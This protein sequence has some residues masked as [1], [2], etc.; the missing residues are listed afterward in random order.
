M[1][2][3]N[4]QKIGALGELDAER[5]FLSWGWNVG[6]DRIDQGYDLFVA[7]TLKKFNGAR[8][9][10]QVKGTANRKKNWVVAQIEKSRLR[11]YA[12][13]PIPVI[14]VR[15][16][17]DCTLYWIHAQAWAESN[18]HR[19]TGSGKAGV[20]FEPERTLSD[21][22]VFESYL[23]E[24]MGK[25]AEGLPS[26][27][28]VRQEVQFLNSVD[29]RLGVRI[30]ERNGKKVHEIYAKEDGFVGK[31]SFRVINKP[32]NLESLE[33]A[34]EYGL[35]RSID[36]ADLTVEGS[37]LFDYMGASSPLTGSLSIIPLA[38][39][40]GVIRLQPGERYS[41][42]E[43]QLFFKAKLYRGIKG[44]AINNEE[45]SGV[46]KVG[47][48][49]GGNV[50]VEINFSVRVGHVCGRPIGDIDE[51]R[52]IY[53]WVQ[54]VKLK[55]S[56]F[57]EF[58]FRNIGSPL[59]GSTGSVAGLKPLLDWL[60]IVSRVHLVAKALDSDF[61]MSEDAEFTF[62]DV[63]SINRAYALLKGEK[64]PV[65]VSIAEIE[66]SGDVTLVGDR[67]IRFLLRTDFNVML[68]GMSLGVIPIGVGLAGYLIEC[69]P[70]SK[71]LRLVAGD[72]AKAFVGFWEDSE[73]ML[74]FFDSGEGE[75][76][77]A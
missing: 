57:A 65:S 28:L 15:A 31:F 76:C 71:D 25:V 29:H 52:E 69:I 70:G 26:S 43:P 40:A 58:D 18:S 2:F 55:N 33:E 8:F 39:E 24:Q 67:D 77:C 68:C 13:N 5:V 66:P 50:S 6:R 27:A 72:C 49:S 17:P 46:F 38:G 37:P 62:E 59:R 47:V 64:I 20:R 22:E 51:L 75:A 3:A 16:A 12:I 35:P 56:I 30:N 41:L 74:S 10:V 60:D 53:S 1:N 45:E 48:K 44:L 42:V 36:V 21:R 63:S 9:L 11:E 19:L 7:P 34:I 32:G 54:R 14:I 73:N 61:V 23:L 4:N